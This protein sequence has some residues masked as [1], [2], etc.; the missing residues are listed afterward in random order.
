MKNSNQPF[1]VAEETQFHLNATLLAKS[2]DDREKSEDEDEDD[3][4]DES[5]D[6]GDVDP[7][8]GP[9]PSAP[10]SAV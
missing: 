1:E 4:D 2:D 3:T 10:G 5:G 9:A 6:W 7:A 8:G